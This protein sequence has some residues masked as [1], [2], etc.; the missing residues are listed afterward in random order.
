MQNKTMRWRTVRP[1]VQGFTLIEM[2]MIIVVMG[3]MA[4]LAVPL[5]SSFS[6]LAVSEAARKIQGDLRYAQELAVTSNLHTRVAFSTGSNNYTVTQDNGSGT[7]VAIVDPLTKAS[8]FVVS[9]S[10]ITEYKNL[11]ITAVSFGGQTTL[12]FDALGRPYSVSGGTATIFAADGTVTLNSATVITVTR[13][14]G[15]VSF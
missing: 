10:T 11:S 3:I 5:I 2:V 1:G 6:T 8:S 4:V 15:M 14:T 9:F 7:Y 12:E 13:G